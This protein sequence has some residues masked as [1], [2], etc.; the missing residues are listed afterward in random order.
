MIGRGNL[1]AETS[2]AEFSAQYQSEAV[3]V[4]T[5]TPQLLVTALTKAGLRPS[6]EDDGAIVV[7]GLPASQVGEIAAGAAL[8]LHELTPVRASLEDAFMELTSDSV[9]Y[10]AHDGLTP[11]GTAGR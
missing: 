4:L 5:P 1:I 7:T 10:R 8:T 2:V 9:E 3:R 6:V 11:A